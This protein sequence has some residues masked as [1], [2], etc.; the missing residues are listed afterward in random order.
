M[1]LGRALFFCLKN[2]SEKSL[3]EAWDNVSPHKL[4]L[5]AKLFEG[6]ARTCLLTSHIW[7]KIPGNVYNADRSSPVIRWGVFQRDQ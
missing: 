3:K 4:R 7:S 6:A 2:A 5:V 1:L